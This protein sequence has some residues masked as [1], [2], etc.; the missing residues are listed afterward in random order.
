LNSGQRWPA[1]FSFSLR[2]SLPYASIHIRKAIWD[3]G[4]LAQIHSG[5]GSKPNPFEPIENEN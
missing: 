3:K 1:L 4:K 5:F 2:A